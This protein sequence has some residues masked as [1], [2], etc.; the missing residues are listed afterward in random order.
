MNIKFVILSFAAMSFLFPACDRHEDAGEG[1]QI[2]VEEPEVRPETLVTDIYSAYPSGMNA[3]VDSYLTLTFE[4]APALGTS[5]KIRI[6]DGNGN[7]ADMIDISDM[8]A[9]AGGKPELT[10]SSP[11]TTAMDAVKAGSYYRIVYYNAVKV[12]G[13]TVTIRLHSGKLDFGRTYSVEIDPEAIVADGFEGISGDE[14]TFSVMEKPDVDGTVTVG[15][16]DCD[17]M[18]V[19]GAV[20]FAVGSYGQTAAVTIDVSDGIYEEPLYIRYKDNLTIRGEGAEGTVIRF[21]N[22]YDYINSVGSGV[23]AVP[24]IGEP[25]GTPGGRS[26]ILV[27]NCDM[28]RFEDISLENSHGDGCQAEVIYF[29][30]DDGRLVA[31]DCRFS[32]EQDT[33]ELKG[34]SFFS[35]CTITGDVDFIWGYPKTALFHSCEIRSCDAGYIVQA[36]CDR[37][38]KGMVF[39]DCSIVADHNVA[40]GKVY[41]ARSG[42]KS[43][44]YDNVAYINC[45]M[46]SHIAASGWHSE[47]T[48][49]P[50]RADAVNGWKE[51]G[52]MDIHGTP[53]DL[54]GRYYGSYRLSA[55]EV[56]AGYRDVPTVFSDCPY[57]ADWTE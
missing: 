36:R 16:K 5:G 1:D 10:A 48:P 21:D 31:V 9:I 49:N 52:T 11:F 25:V 46:D 32:S 54:S 19:Q 51:Y 23:R 28:L 18:T 2:P 22:C 39:M 17:F 47:K 37:G 29:N 35:G 45:V 6:I 42:G 26:V 13:N 34:W 57:G 4:T 15:D 41:L 38:Y 24:A 50:A 33:I 53:A 7:E 12:E 8:D 27:E 40:D 44:E 3:C 14:W 30:S 43:S 55:S 20:N 56:D